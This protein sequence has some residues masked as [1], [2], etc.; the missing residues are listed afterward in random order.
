MAFDTTPVAA[1]VTVPQ[2]QQTPTQALGGFAELQNAF[3][4]NKMFQAKA[5]AGQYISQSVGPD[6]QP[7]VG[8]LNKFLQSD[9]RT[10]P[11]AADILQSAASLQGQGIT[12]Q[13]GQTNLRQQ[14]YQNLQRDIATYGHTSTAKDPAQQLIENQR[15]AARA[16]AQGVQAGRYPADL[17]APYMGGVGQSNFSD[18]VRAATIAGAGGAGAQ[19]AM[20]G[21]PTLVAHGGGTSIEAVN[22][23][24]GTSAPMGEVPNTLSPGEESS[25]VDTVDASGQH[26]LIP[27]SAI[28]TPTGQPK[29]NVPGLTDQ[30]GA[31]TASLPPGGAEAR[32]AQGQASGAQYASDLADSNLSGQ[33]VA[34]LNELDRL[35]QTPEGKTGPG[36]QVVN[37]WRNFLLGNLPELAQMVPGGLS[38]AQV[39]SATQDEL[40]KYMSQLALAQSGAYG[41]S[42]NDKLAAA[43]S[44]NANVDMSNLANQ[45]VTRMNL[46]L[47]RAKQA[48]IASFQQ[49]GLPAEEYSGFAAR[50]NRQVDPRGFMLDRLSKDERSK[51]LGSI[52]TD[53]D[54]KALLR[55]K[56]AAESAGLY[57]EGDIPR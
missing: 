17:A 13:T 46:A 51:M 47:E 5:L 34:T 1:Q 39:Q 28:V 53:A 55:A 44:G 49:S 54:K 37:H 9:P 43:A 41:P 4:Q 25:L 45:A 52:T 42:T 56:S 26:K 6:G 35:L 10:A 21:T 7:D 8:K 2:P 23:Y 33:R 48:R 32:A 29:P 3:N 30:S 31:L 15:A 36:T 18:D 57:Q 22:P 12:N 16:I 24:Q 50:W 11:Y 27:K 19:T 38:E 14:Q 40:K 20:T